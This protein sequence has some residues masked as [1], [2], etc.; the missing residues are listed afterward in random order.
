MKKML[1]AIVATM[2]MSMT[3]MAQ[4]ATDNSANNSMTFERLSSYLELTI[5]QIEPVKTAM[6]QFMLSM[7]SFNQAANERKGEA[8]QKVYD[9]HLQR[10]GNILDEQQMKKYE[11]LMQITINNKAAAYEDRQAGGQ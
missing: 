2:M 4:S 9:Q 10:M 11:Q 1:F 3:A 5:N 7:E 8:W 6:Q